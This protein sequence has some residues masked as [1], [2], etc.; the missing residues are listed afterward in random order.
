MHASLPKQVSHN[1]RVLRA[2]DEIAGINCDVGEFLSKM[3][4]DEP[5]IVCVNASTSL[6]RHEQHLGGQL[7]MQGD[8]HMSATNIQ[9]DG[10]SNDA[11]SVTLAAV[12]EAVDW[13]HA[14]D[15]ALSK[16]P[17][18]RVVIHPNLDT[19]DGNNLAYQKILTACEKYAELPRFF[20][21]DSNNLESS[22]DPERVSQWMH[23]AA[24]I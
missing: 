10:M 2:E 9:L 7:W 1:Q 15:S 17:G 8:R 19:E 5:A 22:V 14:M 16:R 23:T 12:A 24:Q 20:P 18:P 3:S 6:K 21:S 13:E 4:A 11:T